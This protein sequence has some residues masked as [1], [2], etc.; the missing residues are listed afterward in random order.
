MTKK[1]ACIPA[2]SLHV[3]LGIAWG[4]FYCKRKKIT[5]LDAFVFEIIDQYIYHISINYDKTTSSIT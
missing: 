5:E 3:I 4:V 1:I 2:R